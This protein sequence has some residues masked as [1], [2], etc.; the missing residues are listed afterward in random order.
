MS[1]GGVVRSVDLLGR[2]STLHFYHLAIE[3]QRDLPRV[4]G[5]VSN[6]VWWGP[7]PHVGQYGWVARCHLGMSDRHLESVQRSMVHTVLRTKFCHGGVLL[8]KLMGPWINGRG[9]MDTIS[10]LDVNLH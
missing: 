4:G 2:R 1:V 7:D 6:V 5:K 9:H 10:T 3:W 8:L